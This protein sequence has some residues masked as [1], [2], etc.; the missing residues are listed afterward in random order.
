MWIHGS[1]A[2]TRYMIIVHAEDQFWHTPK[3]YYYLLVIDVS[4]AFFFA[5]GK[6]FSVL[7]ERI[8]SSKNHN[9]S[10]NCWMGPV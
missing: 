3:H 2:Y 5:A 8:E 9:F 7:K 6:M 4:I 10:T 1:I